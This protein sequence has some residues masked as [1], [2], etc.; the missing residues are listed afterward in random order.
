[1]WPNLEC[2]AIA[3]MLVAAA[4]MLVHCHFLRKELYAARASAAWHCVLVQNLVSQIEKARTAAAAE[5]AITTDASC[6]ALSSLGAQD[7]CESVVTQLAAAPLDDDASSVLFSAPSTV[8]KEQMMPDSAV[9][10]FDGGSA[11]SS[12]A[13]TQQ[14]Q[15]LDRLLHAVEEESLLSDFEAI[16]ESLLRPI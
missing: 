15:Q 2:F 8:Q 11:I 1:M 7:L 4:V 13:S 6:T 3:A 16:T 5:E 9:E 12:N 10:F 14:Q